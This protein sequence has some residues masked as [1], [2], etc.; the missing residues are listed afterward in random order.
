MTRLLLIAYTLLLAAVWVAGGISGW[1]LVA[2]GAV[3]FALSVAALVVEGE[4]V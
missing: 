2:A 4:R 3:G 1:L